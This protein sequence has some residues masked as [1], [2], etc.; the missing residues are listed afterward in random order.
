MTATHANEPA[1]DKAQQVQ[2]ASSSLASAAV[3]GAESIGRQVRLRNWLRTG[4][5]LFSSA[6]SILAATLTVIFLLVPSLRPDSPTVEFSAS[7]SDAK[8]ETDVVLSDYYARLRRVPESDRSSEDLRK[9]G[10]IVSYTVVIEGFQN[11]ECKLMWS[12]LDAETN[13]RVTEEWLVNRPGW[14]DKSFIAEGVRDQTNGE[15]FVQNPPSPGSYFVRLELLDPDGRRIATIDSPTFLVGA[16]SPDDAPSL[17]P[18]P[19]AP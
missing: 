9:R 2:D 6:V 12:V 1:T 15:T 16:S 18:T 10:V 11:Q 14:P 19:G 3:E 7:L 17:F 4:T 13:K 8:I 5:G